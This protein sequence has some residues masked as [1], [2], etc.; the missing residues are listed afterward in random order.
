MYW[1]RTNEPYFYEGDLETIKKTLRDGIAEEHPSMTPHFLNHISEKDF[2]LEPTA[3]EVRDRIA[4][5]KDFSNLTI[6]SSSYPSEL[7]FPTVSMFPVISLRGKH[8]PY[9]S[10]QLSLGIPKSIVIKERIGITIETPRTNFSDMGGADILI[11]DINRMLILERMGIKTIAG[12][13]LF[14]V[15][16]AGKSF[17]ASSFAGQSGK[18]FVTLDLPHFM[19]L[20][21]PTNAVDE[22]FDF[23]EE[24]SESYVLLLD[25]IEKMFDFKGNN[26]VA[27]QVFG[28][29]LTRLSNIYNSPDNNITFVATANNITDIMLYS[30]EFLRKGRFDRLYFLGY[31]SRENAYKIF[32]LYKN[33]NKKRLYSVLDSLYT[34]FLGEGGD[35]KYQY[36]LPFFK[37]IEKGNFSLDDL[38]KALFLNFNIERNII[39]IESK[40]KS[41]KV[42]DSDKFIY[43]PPEIQSVSEELQN[44]ALVEALTASKNTSNLEGIKLYMKRLEDNDSFTYNII[45]FSVPLQVSASD[46][47]S[48]QVAQSKS[49]AHEDAGEINLFINVS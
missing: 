39:Y 29:L 14:G 20:P 23:L 34:S 11:D 48:R 46:G 38:K 15:A 32:E 36:L 25:E 7:G 47:I 30:P 33:K 2:L 4:I 44:M 37:S 31:P 22:L 41:V 28:K 18:M 6:L 24:Q 26:L 3:D 27:K 35:E 19:S 49:Y 16:G 8:F 1:I 9:T 13:F 17:F 43:S 42:A 45:K 10:T 21:S 12:L 5:G 40:F